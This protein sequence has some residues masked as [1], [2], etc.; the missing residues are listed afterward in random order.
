MDRNILTHRLTQGAAIAA[1]YVVLTMVFAP[2]SFGA[3]QIR[4]S[5]ALTILPLFTPMAIPGLFIGCLLAN[6]LGV[7]SFSQGFMPLEA[8]DAL[9]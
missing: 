2:I 1:L 3:M 8:M 7:S 4:V 5:E 6:L 9:L